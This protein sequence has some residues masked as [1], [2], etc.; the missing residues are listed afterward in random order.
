LVEVGGYFWNAS[1]ST[2]RLSSSAAD[3]PIRAC[4]IFF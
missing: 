1:A 2:A 3:T 4:R